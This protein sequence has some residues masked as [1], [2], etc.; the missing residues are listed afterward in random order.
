MEKPPEVVELESLPDLPPGSP[1]ETEWNT[2]RREL[3]RLLKEGHRGRY[4]LIQGETVA[5]VWDT[6]R[7]GLQAGYER[8]GLTP[9]MV[10]PVVIHQR[11]LRA[12][13]L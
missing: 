2:F 10:Q 4:A 6:F 5:G 12:G 8:F 3:P 9:F 1:L 13:W 7:D 11:P